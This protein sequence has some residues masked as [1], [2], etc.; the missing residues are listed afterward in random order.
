M[1][2]VGTE[3][4][5]PAHGTGLWFEAPGQSMAAV[6]IKLVCEIMYVFSEPLEDS[7]LQRNVPHVNINVSIIIRN[8]KFQGPRVWLYPS[9]MVNTGQPLRL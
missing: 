4:H 7:L 8:S 5:G 6:G 3:W 2:V 1:A 9:K